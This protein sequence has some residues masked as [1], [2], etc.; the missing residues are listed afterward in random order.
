MSDHNI[1][2]IVGG[3]QKFSTE[4]GPGIRTTVFLKGCPLQCRWC[5]NPELIDSDIQLMRCPNN[6]IGCRAC[7]QVCA[8]NAITFGSDG[9]HIDWNACSRCMKCVPECWSKALNA[10]GRRMTVDEVME[11]VL[12]DKDF[13]QNTNGGMTI[14][15]GELLTQPKFAAALMEACERNGIGVA[16][17][18]CGYG[19]VET[20]RSLAGRGSCTHIL[21]DL[22]LIDSE[23]HRKYTGVGNEIIL[24]NLTVLARDPAINPKINMRIPLISGVNDSP[25][26]IQRIC[27]LFLDNGLKSVTLMP[28]HE[29]G[30]SKRRNIG[31]EPE[32]FKAPSAGQ[33]GM[34]NDSFRACGICVEVLGQ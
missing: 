27:K 10:A 18:T 15:G 34:I 20:L 3:I 28:Y 24:R 11:Q 33:I 17:D 4:D 1:T 16:L 19:P 6:C 9:F 22:K 13:Y 12:Q 31:G 8:V 5:H 21:F 2:G 32:L 25:E 14:S 26:H 29:L 7:E 30:V 23:A